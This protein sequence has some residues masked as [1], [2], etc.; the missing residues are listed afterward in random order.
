MN[1]NVRRKIYSSIGEDGRAI[2]VA[3]ALADPLTTAE[4]MYCLHVNGLYYPNK[5][6]K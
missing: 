6:L 2:G 5:M 3:G 1:T 4:M